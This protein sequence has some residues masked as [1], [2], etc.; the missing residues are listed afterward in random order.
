MFK[1]E[2][3]CYIDLTKTNYDL[4]SNAKL[5]SKEEIN[6]TYL[7]LVYKKYCKYEN[8]KSV[9]PLFSCEFYDNDI[10]GYFDNNKLEAFSMVGIYDKENA[11]C[12]Q[13]AWTYH[14]PDLQYGT[15]SVK[16][17]C[18]FYKN[19]GIKKYYLGQVAE[20]KKQFDGFTI[21]GE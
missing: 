21:C 17:E 13:F 9:M 15:L 6:V 3:F 7:Q 12:Y 19:K 1:N 2:K 16:H 20:Y 14:L 8:I 11:E 5:L 18:A 10:I 4:Y